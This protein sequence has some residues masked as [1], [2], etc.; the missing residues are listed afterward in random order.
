MAELGNLI[1]GK[2][3][4]S[5][6]GGG[7]TLGS[8]VLGS[9]VLGG[10]TP[11]VEPRSETAVRM[12]EYLPQYWHEIEEMLQLLN[13]EGIEFDNLDTSSELIL[14]DAFIMTASEK[15]I[16]QWEKWLKLPPTGTLDDRRLAVMRY[17]S[18]ISKLSESAIK[19]MVAT[20]YNDARAYV[21]FDDS[22]IKITIV[23]LPEHQMDELDFSL[24]SEQ[25]YYRKPCHIGT[26]V[27]RS[28]STWGDVRDGRLR[29]WAEFRNLS[30]WEEV[31]MYIPR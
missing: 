24:V 15:R 16:A 1:L 31:L 3:V 2:S 17:F 7:N 25:L 21:R 20:L 6:V 28:F 10:S 26:N 23:P 22:E 8:C 9:M 5:G 14:T 4:L 27:E 11:E 29:T 18:V 19:T 12:M 30:S 13:T